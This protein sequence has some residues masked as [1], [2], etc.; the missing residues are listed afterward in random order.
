M[1]KAQGLLNSFKQWAC[2]AWKTVVKVVWNAACQTACWAS[3]ATAEVASVAMDVAN[4]A[5]E[6]A[7]QTSR[8][9]ASVANWLSYHSDVFLLNSMTA[10]FDFRVSGSKG[11]QAKFDVHL[12]GSLKGNYW[13]ADFEIDFFDL[14]GSAWRLFKQSVKEL[15]DSWFVSER[16][17]LLLIDG[18]TPSSGGNSRNSS[19]AFP[20][21]SPEQALADPKVRA[22]LAAGQYYAA[23]FSALLPEYEGSSEE[24]SMD[25]RMLDQGAE[26]FFANLHEQ[27][28]GRAARRNVPWKRERNG[29][30]L[31][32]HLDQYW[33][34][35]TK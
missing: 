31:L 22:W 23:P 29:Q 13:T 3:K 20:Y 15:L 27:K 21:V 32:D 24:I 5:L 12:V 30:E 35:A 19:S 26:G 6:V 14:V 25:L 17:Q 1:Q 7:K 34:A 16:D 8:A 33:V 4:G 2:K 28:E 9:A 11:N 18:T 10:G